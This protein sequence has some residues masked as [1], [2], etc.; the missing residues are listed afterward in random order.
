MNNDQLSGALWFLIGLAICLGSLQYKLGALS[1]PASGFMPF[2]AGLAVC[3]F[4]GIGFIHATMKKMQGEKWSCLLAGL[5]W[6]NAF[7]ILASLFAYSLLL[8]PLGFLLCTALFIGFL[9]R[10]IVPQ[11]WPVVIGGA[12]ITAVVS[13][14]I[15]EVWLKAQ[16]PKGFLVPYP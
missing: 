2:L 13:Y 10:A 3:I 11:R 14:L 5:T 12:F 7:I 8:V 6:H 15:F 1:S 16:L 9:L 4:A